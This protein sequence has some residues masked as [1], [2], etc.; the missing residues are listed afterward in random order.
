MDLKPIEI[1]PS[2]ATGFVMSPIDIATKALYL[3]KGNLFKSAVDRKNVITNLVRT[4]TNLFGS[5]YGAKLANSYTDNE[6][7]HAISSTLLGTICSA[8]PERFLIQNISKSTR[9]NQMHPLF[10]FALIAR[11]MCYAVGVGCQT[12][13]ND[14][15][16]TKIIKSTFCGIIS[17]PFDLLSN[18][19]ATNPKNIINTL[20]A[21]KP[22]MMLQI[23]AL[24]GFNYAST[25]LVY[26]TIQK[27]CFKTS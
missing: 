8:L 22:T 20:L 6:V 21:Q 14:S 1:I 23:A 26:E 16:Q 12:T 5:T 25:L 10:P 7:A 11:E 3:D 15:L 13:Y 2:L 17:T 18:A 27:Q 9:T 19:A 4:S 24:R